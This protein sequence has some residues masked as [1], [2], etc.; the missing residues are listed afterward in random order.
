MLASA[1]SD[2]DQLGWRHR[3]LEIVDDVYSG[4]SGLPYGTLKTVFSTLDFLQ[5]RGGRHSDLAHVERLAVG[6]HQIQAL[7]GTAGAKSAEAR[8]TR[9]AIR[10]STI[11]W[12]QHTRVND[13]A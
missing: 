9:R 2:A 8:A 6:L 10:R 11:E 1:T 4:D 12:L 5:S 7:C 3:I 13:L